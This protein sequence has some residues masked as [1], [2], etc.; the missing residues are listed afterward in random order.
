MVESDLWIISHTHTPMLRIYYL[1]LHTPSMY[2]SGTDLI[3][4]C[5]V[6]EQCIHSY[7]PSVNY[8]FLFFGGL[9]ALILSSWPWHSFILMHQLNSGCRI[10][11]D[12][13]LYSYTTLQ[14]HKGFTEVDGPLAGNCVMLGKRLHGT[15][16]VWL[17]L[18][19][20]KVDRCTRLFRLSLTV[21]WFLPSESNTDCSW[22]ATS[23]HAQVALFTL[24]IP[25][26]S[27]WL[28]SSLTKQMIFSDIWVQQTGASMTYKA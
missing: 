10:S 16:M 12:C 25:F 17:C 26:L 7:F 21:H 11:V 6:L 2:S 14:F 24:S 27:W 9:T 28:Y 8:F 19:S 1:L 5:A 20:F 3:Q 22:K 4:T 18:S 13:A 23:I 15:L